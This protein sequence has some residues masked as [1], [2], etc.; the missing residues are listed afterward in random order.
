MSQLWTCAG[1]GAEHW[2]EDTRD[3]DCPNTSVAERSDQGERSIGSGSRDAQ[4]LAGVRG[5]EP[6]VVCDDE[7]R[8]WMQ[9]Q[10]DR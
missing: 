9:E 4:S 7:L 5:A 1:C 10:G 3:H 6:P 2:A 8:H